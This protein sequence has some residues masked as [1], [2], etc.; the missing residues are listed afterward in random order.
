[1]TNCALPRS[2]APGCSSTDSSSPPAGC[3][4]GQEGPE[5][6]RRPGHRRTG[7]RSWLRATAGPTICCTSTSRPSA[8]SRPSRRA[9]PCPAWSGSRPCTPKGSP[10]RCGSRRSRSA[11]GSRSSSR[12]RA[13]RPTSPTAT[14]PSHEHAGCSPSP[15]PRRSP[16][17]SATPQPTRRSDLAGEGPRPGDVR[18]VIVDEAH[19]SISWF[20]SKFGM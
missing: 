18:T 1:M 16:A 4:P 19:R 20:R 12:R 17:S 5:P 8:S 10:P 3:G 11:A 7:S 13:P 9:L 15:S 6:V 14:T 2:S